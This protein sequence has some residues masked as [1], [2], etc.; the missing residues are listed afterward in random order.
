[1]PLSASRKAR[2][3]RGIWQRR[4][5]EHTPLEEDDLEAHLDYIHYNPVKHGYVQRPWDWPSAVCQRATPHCASIAPS[6]ASGTIAIFIS[7]PTPC[8][9]GTCVVDMGVN[10]FAIFS[11]RLGGDGGR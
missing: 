8:G 5:W 7:F 4:F 3:E 2:G 9:R 6:L 10:V 1:M 11:P